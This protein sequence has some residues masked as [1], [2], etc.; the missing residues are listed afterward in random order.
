MPRW[1]E[2]RLGGV[3]A[4]HFFKC[5][6]FGFGEE[7]VHPDDREDGHDAEEDEGAEVAGVYEGRGG[8]ADGEVV[9]PIGGLKKGGS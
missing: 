4:H 6:T 2:K 9:E 3:T 5:A 1:V 7:K 8:D